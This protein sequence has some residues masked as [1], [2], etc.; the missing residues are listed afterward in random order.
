MKAIRHEFDRPL[1]L[2]S[3]FWGPIATRDEL[4]NWSV[5]TPSAPSERV[6][7]RDALE[8][9]LAGR[10]RWGHGRIGWTSPEIAIVADYTGRDQQFARAAM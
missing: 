4:E 8:F 5:S 10:V 7:Y 3:Y 9:G 2:L 6:Y 1:K